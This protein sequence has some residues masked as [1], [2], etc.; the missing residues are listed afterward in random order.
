MQLGEG[1]LAVAVEPISAMR[2]SG[3]MRRLRF[4]RISL[5]AIADAPLVEGDHRRGRLFLGF[6]NVNG[7]D[8]IV[9]HRPTIGF[10]LLRSS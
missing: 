9:E 3:S 7:V 6:G 5:P 2:S 8:M 4:L 10:S 1:R